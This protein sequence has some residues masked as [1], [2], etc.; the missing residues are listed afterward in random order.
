LDARILSWR[1]LADLGGDF[2]MGKMVLGY[3]PNQFT[4]PDVFKYEMSLYAKSVYVFLQR[5]Y[6]VEGETVPSKNEI[7]YYVGCSKRK[8]DDAVKELEEAGLIQI[9]KRKKGPKENDTNMYI[10]YHPE[11]I[12]ELEQLPP[13]EEVKYKKKK[14]NQKPSAGDAPPKN[15]VQEMHYPEKSGAGDALP[16]EKASNDA[17]SQKNLVQ[18]MH[19][20][21]LLDLDSKIDSNISD[22]EEIKLAFK[23]HFKEEISDKQAESFVDIAVEKGL[24]LEEVISEMEYISKRV[25]IKTTAAAT[26]YSSLNAGGWAKKKREEASQR[27]KKPKHRLV[28]RKPKTSDL[29]EAIAS[30][31]EE[32]QSVQ[33][34]TDSTADEDQQALIKAK[35]AKM[36]ELNKRKNPAI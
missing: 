36:A 20:T 3:K 24:S 19:G 15:L 8:V 12:Q 6:T 13:Y 35:L 5:C 2:I 30:Q 27:P 9:I 32:A 31:L 29:P 25:K 1:W 7:A 17:G 11:Q 18:E 34:K 4:T 22:D 23:K 33:T 16:P 21:R 26:L 14:K 10:I 28:R